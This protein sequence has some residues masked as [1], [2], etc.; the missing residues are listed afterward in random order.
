MNPAAIYCKVE[1]VYPKTSMSQ[2]REHKQ[3]IS[4]SKL[5]P[6]VIYLCCISALP[7]AYTYCHMSWQK[8]KAHSWLKNGS[9]LYVNEHWKWQPYSGKALKTVGSGKQDS[10]NG[11]RA[12]AIDQATHILYTE[13]IIYTVSKEER[14]ENFGWEGLM[15]R[16][17]G[18]RC[19]N[20]GN[21]VWM[22]L[23]HTVVLIGEY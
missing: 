15:H 17:E 9:N 12:L 14:W 5:D 10:Q 8:I 21:K 6:H 18:W 13:Y 22:T 7:S 19:G 2:T 20:K 16:H 3:A 4:E 1:V 23:Y 11:Q